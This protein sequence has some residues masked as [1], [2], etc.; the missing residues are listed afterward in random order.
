MNTPSS[1]LVITCR[2]FTP[3]IH[4]SCWLAPN[5]TIVGQVAMAEDSSCWF[6]AV[7]R[8]D[9]SPISIGKRV[10]IQDGAVIHGTLD[11]SQTIIEDD[12]SIG[13]NAI[14]HGAHIGSHALIG[15][16][17]VVMDG[18]NIGQGAV[19]AAG[20]VILENT[21]VPPGTLWAGVPARERGMVSAELKQTLADTSMRYVSYTQWFKIP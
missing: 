6:N 4:Y 9:V 11:K 16:G 21:E 7:I 17:A 2:E 3:R 13:H 14:V 5:A 15:M 12:A 20:A 1:G 18:A 10:N 19:I 8:G